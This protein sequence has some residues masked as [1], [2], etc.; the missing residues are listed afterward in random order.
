MPH[1]S[2]SDIWLRYTI[3][4]NFISPI[5]INRR[6]DNHSIQGADYNQRLL[7]WD[8]NNFPA[9]NI[10]ARVSSRYRRCLH[11]GFVGFTS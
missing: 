1:H 9:E 4:R 8:K 10:H 2:M 3:E 5:L 11:D 7:A 6:A